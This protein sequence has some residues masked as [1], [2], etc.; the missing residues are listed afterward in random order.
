VL[1]VSPSLSPSLSPSFLV[2]PTE[3]PKVA[4]MMLE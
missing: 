1:L 2:F 3:L 4:G